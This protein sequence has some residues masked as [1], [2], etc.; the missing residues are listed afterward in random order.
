MLQLI[1]LRSNITV[2]V[3]EKLSVTK[4]NVDESLQRLK[5][6][7]N[8]AV[9]ISTCNRTE[10]YLVTDLIDESLTEN[11]FK[12][13]NWDKKYL[14]FIFNISE[15]KAVEHL[16]EVS[17]GFHSKI[18]GEDQILGQVKNAIEIS[19]KSKAAS[20]ILIR[21]FENAVSCGKEFRNRTKLYS[22]PVSSASIAV[23]QAEKLRAKSFMLIGFGNIN[24]LVYKYI[25]SIKYEIIYIAVR[26]TEKIQIKAENIKI[27]NINEKN[28]FISK[29]DCIIT[30]TSSE[31]PI[32]SKDDFAY[33]KTQYIF[34]LAIPR[35]VSEDAA[36]MPWI[37]VFNIDDISTMDAE[38]KEKRKVLME[39]S[40]Y[41]L[42]KHIE[43]FIQW[44]S[45]ETI[46]PNIKMLKI[47]G[48]LVYKNRF[49]SFKRKSY[50]QDKNILAE[51]LL[52][53][54]SDA[55]INKAIEV[56]K[57]ETLKGKSKECLEL[58]ERI[59]LNAN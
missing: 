50:T 49:N 30:A 37:K 24:Q 8:E 25:T 47:Q 41:I 43:Q 53:S 57:E 14:N 15:R 23:K 48:D 58:I 13:L 19:T 2:D 4:D 46:V 32:I 36:E 55:Y 44:K 40:K 3:R 12:A 22:I 51:T 42:K 26:N 6:F 59:F 1:G 31:N 5:V 38:N 39:S 17:C 9:I 52:K 7:C 29:V 33:E 27:I 10:L 16:F 20:S 56:L 11:V 21:L 18:L 28:N 45:I 54:T 34:D 35:D